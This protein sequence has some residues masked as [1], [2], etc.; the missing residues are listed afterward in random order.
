M[1]RVAKVRLKCGN[2][3]IEEKAERKAEE[4]TQGTA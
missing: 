2:G 4:E 3:E 1:D